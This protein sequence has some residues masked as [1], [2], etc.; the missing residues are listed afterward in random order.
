M[1]EERREVMNILEGRPADYGSSKAPIAPI[2]AASPA[3]SVRSML[4]IGP[5][6]ARPASI[7]VMGTGI[8]SP[9]LR[10]APWTGSMLDPHSTRRRDSLP[11]AGGVHR[12]MSDASSNTSMRP[13]SGSNNSANLQYN[14]DQFDMS[15]TVSWQ[16]KPRRVTHGGKK[17][18]SSMASIIQGRELDPITISRDRDRHNSTAGIL[19]PKS[20][21]SP[22][23]RLNRRSDSPGTRKLN[24]N[25]FNPMPTPGKF[26]SETGKIIDMKNAYRKLSDTNM[27]KS[28]SSLSQ[29]KFTDKATRA[30]LNSGESLSPTGELR[31]EKDHYD[32]DGEDA[33][34]SSDDARTS[35][36]E[37]WGS[38]GRRRRRNKQGEGAEGDDSDADI[39]G[40][41]K[42]A[43]SLLAAAEE[44]RR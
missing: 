11:P 38:R 36:D 19:G 2:R 29:S 31:L 10:N 12:T 8:S 18:V 28:G 27:M 20:S 23:S 9:A 30:R 24:T 33:I 5:A 21:Q 4:D 42:G 40:R 25:S 14:K 7:A 16:A 41:T 32:E 22:S 3:A 13:R 17:G 15:S 44:E 34:E 35:D 39:A 6:P 1:D 26:L 37:A 43:Q